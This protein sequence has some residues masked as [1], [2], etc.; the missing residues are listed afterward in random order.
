MLA[1]QRSLFGGGAPAIDSAFTEARRRTLTDGAWVEYCPGWVTGH[2]QLYDHLVTTMRWQSQR[3]PMYDRTVDVPRLLAS[4]PDDGPGHPLLADMAR[5]LSARYGEDF[6]RMGLALYRDG[7][8]SVAWHGD[9]VARELPEA[10]VATVS[11]GEPRRFL[12]RPAEG[13]RTI[14]FALG[15][16]D[17]LVMGGTCQRTWRHALPKVAHAG[18]RVVIMFR[19]EWTMP[20]GRKR[21]Y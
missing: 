8:D 18:P 2:Q 7:N 14:S 21:A 15:W 20:D 1:G 13:G 12:M 6:T 5:A 17:V 3:V 9:R 10:L 16:G 19:P 4:V 11:L